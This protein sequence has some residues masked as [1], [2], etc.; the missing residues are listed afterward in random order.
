M[1]EPRHDATTEPVVVT[2]PVTGRHVYVAH[3]RSGRPSTG[4]ERCPFC[5]GGREVPAQFETFAFPNRWPAVQ[6]GRC[7]VL[8]HSPRHDLDFARMSV[9]QARLVVDLWARR[10]TALGAL[11]GVRSVLVFENRGAAAG[12]TVQHPHSQIFALPF[13]PPLTRPPHGSTRQTCP[14]CA[15]GFDELLISTVPGWRLTVPAAPPAPHTVRLISDAHVPDLAC[16]DDGARD[17][18]ARALIDAVSRLDQVFDV[19]MPYQLWV[20]QGAAR[21]PDRDLVHL[22]V[23][24]AGLLSSRDRPRILGAAELA[25]GI[26]FTSVSPGE[27]AERLRA[28]ERRGP[29]PAG[30]EPGGPL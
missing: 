15:E 23:T 26:C 29:R 12:A 25:T 4:A 19:P 21:T 24:I 27:A 9:P 30:R 8:V 28:V 1:P 10:T 18:L 17:A 11:P 16:L 22:T 7:E 20:Q 5:P 3:G 6:H 2:D 14:A 13:V